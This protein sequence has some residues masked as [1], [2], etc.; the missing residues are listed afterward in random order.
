MSSMPMLMPATQRDGINRERLAAQ[1]GERCARVREGVHADAEPGDTVAAGDADQAEDQNDQHPEPLELLQH[2]EIKHDD[3]ADEDFEN[4][5][6][7]ALCDQVGF[8]GLVNQL[9]HLAHRGMHRQALELGERHET[10]QQAETADEQASDEQRP[11]VNGAVQK[12]HGRQVGQHQIRFATACRRLGLRREHRHRRQCQDT[13]GYSRRRES[14]QRPLQHLRQHAH[15]TS[16]ASLQTSPQSD[17]RHDHDKNVGL[18]PEP[19]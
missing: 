9:R 10:K 11:P 19:A 3:R 4:Q 13:R 6:E 16:H 5:D 8:A 7:L 17:Q 12:R 14:S 2:P 15:L 1:A 18:Y